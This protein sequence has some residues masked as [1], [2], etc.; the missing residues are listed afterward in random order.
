MTT[1]MLCAGLDA[2][3]PQGLWH[4][5]PAEDWQPQR[6]P[7]DCAPRLC[8]FC[9]GI[10]HDMTGSVF[11]RL[12]LVYRTCML[13]TSSFALICEIPSAWRSLCLW[14]LL[15]QHLQRL[16]MDGAEYVETTH[17]LQPQHK[18]A[19]GDAGGSSSRHIGWL[20][21]RLAT[22]RVPLALDTGPAF[23]A[24]RSLSGCGSGPGASIAH[25]YHDL[26][27]SMRSTGPGPSS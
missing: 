8:D 24:A 1:R 13:H 18:S 7:L 6:R 4:D 20:C 21:S 17:P 27:R 2:H 10:D 9:P 14:L 23:D 5:R 22:H 15:G 25:A 16:Q 12:R 26:H 19:H 11:S 3:I